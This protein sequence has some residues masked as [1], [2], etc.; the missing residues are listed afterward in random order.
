[1]PAIA[2]AQTWLTDVVVEHCGLYWKGQ[3]NLPRGVLELKPEELASTF[4]K[5]TTSTAWPE[6][7]HQRADCFGIKK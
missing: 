6:T 4:A 3:Q 7:G 1:M 2:E 5:R